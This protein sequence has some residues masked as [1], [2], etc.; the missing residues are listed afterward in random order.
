MIKLKFFIA[1]GLLVL[2]ISSFAQRKV[3]LD[4]SCLGQYRLAMDYYVN[5]DFE[6]SLNSLDG[7]QKCINKE[8]SDY[9]KL[10]SMILIVQEKED[11]AKIYISSYVKT[12]FDNY[13]EEN[14]PELF[15]DL[16]DAELESLANRSITSLSKSPEDIEVAPA[17]VLVI[18][19]EDFNKRGYLD[20][21]DLLNDV[22][23][24]DI[25][26][27][28][29]TTYANVYQ[30]GFRQDNTERTLVM[31]DGIEENDIWSN[32]AYLSR[33]Y[34][35]TNISSVEIIYGPA[36]TIY[37]PRSF[38][39]AINIVTKKPANLIKRDNDRDDPKLYLGIN[40]KLTGASYGT[41]VAE[42]NVA[43]SQK[44]FSFLL[45]GRLFNSEGHDMSNT[46]FFD[47]NPND[48]NSLI[49]NEERM[50]SLSFKDNPATTVNELAVEMNRLGLKPGSPFYDY[51]SINADATELKINPDSAQSIL[52]ILK[53]RDFE[54]YN[55]KINGSNVGFS[56]TNKHS[57]F[58]GKVLFNDFEFGFRTWNVQ[59]NFNYYQDLFT[60]GANNGSKWKPL[61]STFYSKYNKRFEYIS[62]SNTLSYAVHGIEGNS[63]LVSYNSFFN[64]L[65][66]NNSSGL[67]VLNFLFPDSLIN[68]DKQGW[69]ETAYFYKAS[70][71]R[72]DLKVN[73]VRDR[74][75]AMLGIE[76]RQSMLQG[77]YLRYNTYAIEEE[78]PDIYPQEVGTVNNQDEGSNSYSVLDIGLYSQISYQFIPEKLYFTA[79]G[80]LDNNKIRS[81]G[82]FGTRFNPKLA[83]VYKLKDVVVKAIFS[84]G[85][86]NPSQFT[87]FST[88]GVRDANP[89]LGPERIRNLEFVV[90]GRRSSKLNW[91]ASIFV[92]RVD[93]AVV[94]ST[95]ERSSVSSYNNVGTYS[96]LGSQGNLMLRPFQNGIS[97]YTNYSLTYSKE[98]NNA[99][100]DGS[101]DVAD[102]AR[103]KA[104]FGLNIPKTINQNQF[105]LNL[106]SNYVG[107][108]LVGP[109]TT[110]PGN[111]GL[112]GTGKIPGYTIF[113][114]SFM[115]SHNKIPSLRLQFTVNNILNTLYYSPG[116]RTADGDYVNNYNGFV[117]YVPQENRNYRLSL[118][119]EI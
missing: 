68:G 118:I 52:N 3:E 64:L 1:L 50:K 72:N 115:Y 32:I 102:I 25:S 86:Q 2:S 81:T 111:M 113:N 69:K 54:K 106:R 62:I 91:D 33:Q 79:A 24:F 110:V 43:G 67:S 31:I 63:K 89:N 4:E 7:Y 49:Y 34:P 59:Q 112:H 40:G 84:Q 55:S 70:Q 35:L 92:S 61:N 108:K 23:G 48:L 119:L 101:I 65:D 82:G 96:I 53:R 47:Y 109:G 38:A 57:Y 17:S 13:Y 5:G 83:M 16:V 75:N 39:G 27:I 28:F 58:G 51:Y 22:P 60:A 26:K 116:P 56:G 74:F 117:P 104:N 41:Q 94:L 10:K 85:I 20:I 29:A 11:E 73:V 88:T 8:S 66:T 103:F 98:I 42:L 87:K 78:R 36:S 18:K 97:F 100:S 107:Q 46:S 30:R 90:Q 37:G 93:D 80:R 95:T 114:T 44:N 9:L 14:D 105:N 99:D 19:E 6:R 21:I 71:I 15:K 76:V 77:D 12:K 45:T